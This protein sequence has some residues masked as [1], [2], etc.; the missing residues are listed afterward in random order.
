MVD[1]TDGVARPATGACVQ[2][3]TA[4][5]SSTGS[6]LRLDSIS[7]S[8]LTMPGDGPGGIAFR[9]VLNA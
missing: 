3:A 1:G 5:S 6:Q 2:P 9:Y 7:T 8:C 4:M